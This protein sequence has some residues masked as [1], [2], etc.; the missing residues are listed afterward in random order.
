MMAEGARGQ[1]RVRG[2]ASFVLAL[3]V[4]AAALVVGS[5]VTSSA[6]PTAAQRAAALETQIRCPSC[7]DVSVAQ[8]SASSAIAVRHEVERLASAGMSDHAIEQRLVAQYGSSILLSPPDSGLSSLVWLLPLV[9]G[10]VAVGGLGVFFWR[11]S[12]SW[13]RLR[14]EASA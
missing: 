12:R 9:A 6:A 3:A 8:S 5:G 2:R 13:R 11:R 14:A 1:R 10:L 7:E 4:L